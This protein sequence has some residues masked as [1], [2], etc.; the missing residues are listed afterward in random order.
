M[1]LHEASTPGWLQ[2]LMPLLLLVV[3]ALLILRGA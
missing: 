1:T 2:A 3:A